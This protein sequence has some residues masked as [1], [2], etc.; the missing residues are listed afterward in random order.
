MPDG[1][2]TYAILLAG[3]SGSRLWP[4]SRQLYPKQLVKFTGNYSLVQNTVRRLEGVVPYEK[5]RVVCGDEHLQETRR[6][7]AELG[8]A[9]EKTIISEPCGRN[10]APAVL[11]AVMQIVQ[12]NE[13]AI[14]L[15]FPADHV[16]KDTQAFRSALQAAIR[17]A[18][19]GHIVTFG[20]KPDYPETGYGYIEGGGVVSEEALDVKRFVEKPDLLTAEAYVEAGNFFWNSGMFAFRASVVLDEFKT[21]A[22][23]LYQMMAAL[24]TANHNIT[25]EQYRHLPDISIDYAIME[26]TDKIVVWP[27][28]FGWSDIGTWKALYD[29]L[30][31]DSQGNV[32]DGDVV[33]H[34]TQNCFIMGRDRLIATNT[35][36]NMVLVE[37]PDAVFASPME[38]SRDVKSIVEKLKTKGRPEYRKHNQVY[39][40]WGSASLIEEQAGYRVRRLVVYPDAT[41]TIALPAHQMKK[42]TVVQGVARVAEK[43]LEKRRRQGSSFDVGANQSVDITNTHTEP[44]YLIEIKIDQKERSNP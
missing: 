13:D 28:D 20:I 22:G 15:V 8:L 29:F 19:K 26:K 12:K 41:L 37:T 43:N 34:A 9:G 6:H 27:S 24:H 38:D 18:E 35:L 4:V 25:A 10:T 17:L 42:I 7:L 44:L 23:D 14:L 3:G 16:V 33:T 30:P 32:I 36:E 21:H 40:A 31:K 2:D 5:V 11:L 39:H 1:I